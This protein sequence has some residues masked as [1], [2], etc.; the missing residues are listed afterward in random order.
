[1][2]LAQQ[3]QT[4]QQ[5][6]LVQMVQPELRVLPV[7]QL[8]EQLVQMALQVQQAH[9]ARL[10]LLVQLALEEFLES[11]AQLT[12][13]LELAYSHLTKASRVV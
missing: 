7:I 10:V 3:V 13:T 6:P 1:V 5:A 11:L 2:L 4:A 8:Q 12:M 9:K